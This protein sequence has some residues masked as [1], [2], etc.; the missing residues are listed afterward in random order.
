MDIF[1]D[2]NEGKWSRSDQIIATGN[3]S[4]GENSRLH[5]METGDCRKKAYMLIRYGSLEGRFGSLLTT[6]NHDIEYEYEG[7]WIALLPKEE[8]EPIGQREEQ[9]VR[10]VVDGKT[11]SD[12]RGS[13]NL[14]SEVSASAFED[15][16][17]VT[18][19]EVPQSLE[20]TDC[21]R[22]ERLEVSIFGKSELERLSSNQKGMVKTIERLSTKVPKHSDLGIAMRILK[23]FV[24]NEKK[25]AL[26]DMSGIMRTNEFLT[27]K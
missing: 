17:G 9:T 27:L 7:R 10:S 11:G 6:T 22:S 21:E 19:A 26:S 3:V 13:A 1:D 8:E 2:R 15:G 5:I 25:E 23:Y 16:I 4:L 18:K 24:P 20:T 14:A 12:L